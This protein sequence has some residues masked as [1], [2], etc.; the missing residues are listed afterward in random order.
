MEPLTELE[1][2]AEIELQK[3]GVAE[4]FGWWLAGLAAFLAYLSWGSWLVSVT[5]FF[6]SYYIATYPYRRNERLATDTYH[7]VAGLGKYCRSNEDSEER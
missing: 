4:D 6:S 2:K 5:V 1:R 3:L 7:R